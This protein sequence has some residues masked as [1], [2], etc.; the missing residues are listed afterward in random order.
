[1]PLTER[2]VV[3]GQQVRPF[4]HLADDLPSGDDPIPAVLFAPE[5]RALGP[6]LVA[7]RR[8]TRL[9]LRRVLVKINY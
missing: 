4:G 9:V 2:I 1:V 8:E 7:D 3:V 5:H 6:K